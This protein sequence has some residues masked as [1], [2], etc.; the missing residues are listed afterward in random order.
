MLKLDATLFIV[1][2]VSMA[3]D[4][5]VQTNWEAT[6]KFTNWKARYVHSLIYATLSTLTLTL[7]GYSEMTLIWTYL[8]LLISHFFI[9]DRKL[10]VWL[11]VNVKRIPRED[12]PGLWWMNIG[13]DQWLHIIVIFIISVVVNI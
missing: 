10:V 13:I 6:N 4:W 5:I 2:F 3:Y 1:L 9:D 12:I 8:A 11:M 7:F